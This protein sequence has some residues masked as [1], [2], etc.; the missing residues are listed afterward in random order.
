MLISKDGGA[1]STRS[2]LMSRLI[3]P[4]QYIRLIQ[5]EDNPTY[6]V[7]ALPQVERLR[8]MPASIFR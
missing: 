4:L 2:R 7:L 6:P 5:T 1:R 3:F 8:R